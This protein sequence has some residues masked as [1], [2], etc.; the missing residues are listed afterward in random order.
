MI[1]RWWHEFCDAMKRE[2]QFGANIIWLPLS[3]ALGA[4]TWFSL[5]KDVSAIPL[6]LALAAACT[7]WF[8]SRRIRVLQ[9]VFLLAAGFV[10]AMLAAQVE[11]WRKDTTLLDSE[12]TTR[13]QGIV[14]AR[15]LDFKGH[16][17]YLIDLQD[18]TDPQINRPPERIRLI[19]RNKHTPIAI[20]DLIGGLA[21]LQPPSGAALP[22]SYDFAFNAYFNGIGAYGF[23]MGA[24]KTVVDA[25]AS[26][27]VQPTIMRGF[28]LTLAR[29]REGIAQR[30]NA[31][32]D[33][34]TAG[35]A[36][37][38]TV[39]DRRGLHPETVDALRASGLAH[40][41]AISGLHMALVA[42]TLF[43]LVRFGCSLFP[44]VIQSMPVKK[45][46][47][48]A[49]LL[50]ATLYL[51]ISGASIS[52]Q[53]AWI[54]LAI[55]LVAVLLDRPALTMRN[56]AL[57]AIAIILLSPS[58]VLGPGFQMSFAATAALI[59]S[60]AL[61]NNDKITAG[62][63]HPS[64]FGGLTRIILL[65]F[66]GLAVTSLV[67]GLATAP[68]SSYHFHKVASYGLIA[69]LL[70]MP[71]ITFIVMPSGLIA[72]LVMPLGLEHWPLML[73]GSG[74]NL[75][76]DIAYYVQGLGGVVTVGRISAVSFALLVSGFLILVLMRTRLRLLG[77]IV[78]AAGMA[79]NQWGKTTRTP[80]VLVAE[81]GRLVAAMNEN[82]IATHRAR[83]SK[84]VFQQWQ[85]AF[86]REALLKPQKIKADADPQ[87]PY[88]ELR[89]LLTGPM[90]KGQF[91]CRS[92]AYCALQTS[93]HLRVV[94]VEDLIYL[95]PAC[96]E[97]DLVIT[98]R[99]IVM[100]RCFSGA[101]LITGTMLRQ[102]G[103]LEIHDDKDSATLLIKSSIGQTDRPWTRHRTY[104]WR[105]QK[106]VIKIPVW[107]SRQVE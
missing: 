35:F 84:F 11:T 57:A 23:F 16:R 64:V 77:I 7:G 28:T 83:P 48:F 100:D 92:K 27:S 76:I 97:A 8:L 29:V 32:L 54:M 20:G 95:G 14:V 58:A 101:T 65:F 51:M 34:D 99:R 66:I 94:V 42:G 46:A 18:T 63:D 103:S 89:D 3:M 59:A 1:Y 19:A 40:V 37:A 90:P 87:G 52:T 86:Q 15:D 10:M 56:V 74:L 33:G 98:S 88:Q 105:Q 21:R 41:L 53:R 75:V 45:Y 104:D 49:A 43:F 96:D 31:V 93:S 67:A 36:R 4:A 69:N 2:S 80:D 47:A 107:A 25:Q 72:L 71:I 73:M 12:I 50:V 26:T 13:I 62:R 60:Y 91:I 81:N 22:G 39:A 9:F 68:F 79:Y 38:L 5:E 17:R 30:I 6:A 55:V 85:S 44:S 82:S 78:I 106:H 102:S 24:P 61:W 70:A